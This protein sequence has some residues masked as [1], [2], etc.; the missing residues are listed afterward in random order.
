MIQYPLGEGG[1][2]GGGGLWGKF[3]I[4]TQYQTLSKN[5]N[6]GLVFYQKNPGPLSPWF[7]F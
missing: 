4:K 7:F 1:G 5:N 3:E 2:G 6:P